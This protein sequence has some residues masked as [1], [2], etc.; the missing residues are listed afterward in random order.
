[1]NISLTRY[2]IHPVNNI[3]EKHDKKELELVVETLYLMRQN[4]VLHVMKASNNSTHNSPSD[5]VKHQASPGLTLSEPI[6][7]HK[8]LH[9]MQF[10]IRIV[11]SVRTRHNN[12]AGSS[13]TY[14]QYSN[15][16]FISS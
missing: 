9:T 5:S 16:I 11:Q 12:D 7:H 8:Y 1:M 4:F 14:S 15:A 2:K 13:A 3:K 6:F 10:N